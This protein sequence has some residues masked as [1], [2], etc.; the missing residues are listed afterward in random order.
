MVTV[1]QSTLS[2]RQL[3]PPLY[4]ADIAEGITRIIVPPQREGLLLRLHRHRINATINHKAGKVSLR[5]SRGDERGKES[6]SP[7]KHPWL[8]P[9]C[10]CKMA[11]FAMQWTSRQ[12]AQ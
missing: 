2:I 9:G 8:P 4:F 12:M 7:W 5:A 11:N 10:F 1:Q 3:I 6:P